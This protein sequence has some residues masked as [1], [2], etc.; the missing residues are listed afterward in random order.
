MVSLGHAVILRIAHANGALKSK[1]R[2]IRVDFS[3]VLSIASVSEPPKDEFSAQQFVK[4]D[5]AAENASF[6]KAAASGYRSVTPMGADPF[7]HGVWPLAR[8]VR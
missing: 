8:T 5:V 1:S 4:S 7:D 6:E 2:A 3:N